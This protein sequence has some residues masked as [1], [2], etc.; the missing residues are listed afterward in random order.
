MKIP[1]TIKLRRRNKLFNIKL[2]TMF[3]TLA[4][5]P[6]WKVMASHLS[7]NFLYSLPSSEKIK[8]I[9]IFKQ[10]IF[11]LTSNKNTSLLRSFGI[12]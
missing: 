9:K 11:L 4:I 3:L 8:K 5:W 7:D 12:S 10:N 6:H 2:N 1:N